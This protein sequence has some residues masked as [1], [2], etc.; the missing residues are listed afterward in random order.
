MLEADVKRLQVT[1]SSLEEAFYAPVAPGS[2]I[3]QATSPPQPIPVEA[4][5]QKEPT[6]I[7]QDREK[8]IA[9]FRKTPPNS[10]ARTA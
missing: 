6:I 10:V 1:Y 3:A 7:I 9:G 2:T 4:D 5:Q 8:E